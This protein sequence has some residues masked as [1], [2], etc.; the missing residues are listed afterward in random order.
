MSNTLRDNQIYSKRVWAPVLVTS[1]F[2]TSNYPI[3][4][5]W[6]EII[7]SIHVDS[8][9]TSAFR[10]FLSK[11]F[12]SSLK[13]ITHPPPVTCTVLNIVLNFASLSVSGGHSAPDVG[14][15][16]ND[17]DLAEIWYILTLGWYKLFHMVNIQKWLLCA[18]GSSTEMPS[19]FYKSQKLDVVRS[20]WNF[21]DTRNSC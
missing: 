5:F 2:I 15:K 6:D 1:H 3:R 13:C 14:Q 20:G 8:I 7:R 4:I 9:L 11:P 18:N 12:S 16:Q 21:V 19:P 17:S 10:S